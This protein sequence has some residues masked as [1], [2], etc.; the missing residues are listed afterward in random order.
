[1]GGAVHRPL[2]RAGRD[3]VVSEPQ[4]AD[5]WLTARRRTTMI[6]GNETGTRFADE[7]IEG[8]RRAAYVELAARAL[9][10]AMERLDVP[11]PSATALDR[12]LNVAGVHPVTEAMVDAW[13]AAR[14]QVRVSREVLANGGA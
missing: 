12:A 5:E 6:V 7:L 11:G 14:D 9:L 13:L 4:T 8:R 2:G 1:M 10:R 3:G